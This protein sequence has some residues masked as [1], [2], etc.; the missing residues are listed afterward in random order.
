MLVGDEAASE[1]AGIYGYWL[2]C[3]LHG[4]ADILSV[5]FGMICKGWRCFGHVQE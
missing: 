5:K 1:G 2:G 3:R 4:V